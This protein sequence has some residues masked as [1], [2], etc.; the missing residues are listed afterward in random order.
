MKTFKIYFVK[1]LNNLICQNKAEYFFP[2]TIFDRFSSP[3]L[4]NHKLTRYFIIFNNR[5]IYKMIVFSIFSFRL[6]QQILAFPFEILSE[7]NNI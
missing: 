2:Q 5:I 6:D 3:A 1:N 4:L 7:D